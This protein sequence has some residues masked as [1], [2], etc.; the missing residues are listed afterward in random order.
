M[1]QMDSIRFDELQGSVVARTRCKI[2]LEVGHGPIG[3]WQ[4]YPELDYQ[5]AGP[6]DIM[7]SVNGQNVVET[8]EVEKLVKTT[9]L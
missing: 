2:A 7:G 8:V 1:I 4:A 6:L 3:I 9:G 5:I